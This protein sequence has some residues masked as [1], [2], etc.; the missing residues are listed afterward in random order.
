MISKKFFKS[1]IIYS[2]IGALPLA[3]SFVLLLF[4]ANLLS[5]TDLGLLALYIVIALL[6]QIIANFA[7]DT[8]IG[9]HYFE[10]KDHPEKLKKYVGTIAGL[11]I[12][13]GVILALFS[14]AAGSVLF[15]TLWP[16]NDMKFYPYG[17]LSILTGITNSFFKT[18]T[19]LLINQEKPERYFWMNIVMFILTL[20]FSL[21]LLFIF[22][23]TLIGP[24]WGRFL[25][26]IVS[27]AI[28]FFFFRKEFGISLSR[29]LFNGIFIFCFPVFL[30]IL[31][32]W[33]LSSLDRFIIKA[34]MQASDVAVYDFIVKCTV[35]MEFIQ[36][37]L[38][39]AI[40]PKVFNLFKISDRKEST[41]EMNRYFNG[42]TLV[43]LAVIPL[44][45]IAI[46]LI[47]PLLVKNH[48]L[49][50][51]FSFVGI[52]SLGF[53]TRSLYTMYSLPIYYFKK[54]RRLPVIFSIAA[55]VQV[56]L[57]IL[58]I[59]QFGLLGVVYAGFISK[60]IQ[61]FLLY[62]GSRSI[63]TFRIN[64][65]KQFYLPLFYVLLC[66]ISFFAFQKNPGIWVYGAQLILIY[67]ATFIVFRTELFQ[68]LDEV[69]SKRQKYIP[70]FL[71]RQKGRS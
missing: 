37:G 1:S 25:A 30:F 67:A 42:F 47:I 22:P 13:I 34:L 27:A 43:N 19:N 65:V 50:K 62:L 24:I 60:F 54:T 3:T 41:I 16:Q 61:V 40:T 59:K 23:K 36:S 71:L 8:S 28:A 45:I 10:V 14:L 64:N 38:S 57:S 2:V 48:E 58:G 49:Y 21:G 46:P 44:M 52:L 33:V 68:L 70:G 29:S 26:S 35:M 7:M 51:G 12:I 31:L 9:V 69:V 20:V 63:F 15:K 6:V 32:A 18:Y 39:S 4:Y 56:S 53:V 55:V 5:T 17:F 11:L 66:G